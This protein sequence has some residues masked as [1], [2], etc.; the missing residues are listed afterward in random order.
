MSGSAGWLLMI[1]QSAHAG[2]IYWLDILTLLAGYAC[3]DILELCLC[4]SAMLSMLV[5]Y[6]DWLCCL[7]WVPMLEGYDGW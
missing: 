2:C 4:L 7:S 1:F 3:Y 5:G 6:A